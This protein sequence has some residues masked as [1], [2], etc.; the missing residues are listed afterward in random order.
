MFHKHIFINSLQSLVLC[1]LW[2]LSKL[3]REEKEDLF[4]EAHCSEHILHLASE[5]IHFPLLFTLLS[6]RSAFCG[7]ALCADPGLSWLPKAFPI[8]VP[9]LITAAPL[10]GCHC[11][12]FFCFS[13][14]KIKCS[15][16]PNS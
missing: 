8:H 10:C 9:S 14:L 15:V 13:G 5:K 2:F 7:T 12:L 6:C 16:S 3:L 11:P 4:L 1:G